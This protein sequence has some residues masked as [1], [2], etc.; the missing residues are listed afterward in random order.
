M[1]APN[2]LRER[3]EHGRVPSDDQLAA[4]RSTG[5]L[6][7]RN[8]VD[9]GLLERLIA[10][11]DRLWDEGRGL[12]QKTAHYDLEPAHTAESPRIR[13]IAS[14]TELDPVF[15]DVAFNSVLG[16]IAADWAAAGFEDTMLGWNPKPE[17]VHGNETAVQPGVQA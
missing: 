4:Y 5:F 17:V 8:C 14:P 12:W 9:R 6:T 11:T 10:V 3:R 1:N 16:D 2:D 7:M 13:R 15:I